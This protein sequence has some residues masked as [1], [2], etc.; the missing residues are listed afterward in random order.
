LVRLFCSLSVCYVLQ[1]VL[2]R[3]L[4]LGRPA[5]SSEQPHLVA[6]WPPLPRLVVS[7]PPSSGL[8]R[9]QS[10]QQCR[11]RTCSKAHSKAGTSKRSGG[12][13]GEGKYRRKDVQ[14]KV[15]SALEH[16]VQSMAAATASPPAVVRRLHVVGS[17]H[18]AAAPTDHRSTLQQ[19]AA[20][21]STPRNARVREKSGKH[22]FLLFGVYRGVELAVGHQQ[23]PGIGLAQWKRDGLITH[24]SV[25]LDSAKGSRL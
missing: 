10:P 12:A 14:S 11:R 6:A 24:R 1:D 2:Q 18:A 3:L 25:D 23:S 21:G 15:C 5:T 16:T 17:C 20:R 8:G 7:A 4:R 13:V 19:H 22:D 9:Q